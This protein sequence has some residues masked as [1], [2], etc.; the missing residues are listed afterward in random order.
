M[1]NVLSAFIILIMYS[2]FRRANPCDQVESKVV[3]KYIEDEVLPVYNEYGIQIPS[4]CV[5][6]LEN[7]L[8]DVYERHKYE[9]GSSK[10][11][12]QFCGKAF[13]EE[14]FLNQHFKNRHS[15]RLSE[16]RGSLC[17]ADYC[18]IFRCEVMMRKQRPHYWDKALCKS[19]VLKDRKA[20]CETIIRE[21]IP[22][23][24]EQEGEEVL[25]KALY[26]K[27]CHFLS[28]EYYWDLPRP[29]TPALTVAGYIVAW[30]F[31]GLAI[32]VYYFITCTHFFSDDSVV[33]PD[34]RLTLSFEEKMTFFFPQGKKARTKKKETKHNKN[35]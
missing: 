5:M 9:E 1:N 2:L 29:K 11:I 27:V 34:H 3:R 32:F 12:C 33:D 24:L 15:S 6:L 25:H 35:K 19:N 8:Y 14:R 28:C 23:S 10:W 31:L 21:C 7:D 18:H 4:N 26:S 20:Q 16:S 22:Q 13:Y 30:M 17:M